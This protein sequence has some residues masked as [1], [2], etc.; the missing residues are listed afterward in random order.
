MDGP[1]SILNT[2]LQMQL[3]AVYREAQEAAY[4]ALRWY[5]INAN[6]PVMLGS[7]QETE[8]VLARAWAL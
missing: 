5:M 4:G 6:N 1:T 3:P 8:E 2:V 7:E